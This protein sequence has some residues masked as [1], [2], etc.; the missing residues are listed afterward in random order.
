M[1]CGEIAAPAPARSRGASRMP[2]HVLLE[3]RRR[4][5]SFCARSASSS[6]SRPWRRWLEAGV[7][8]VERLERAAEALARSA[9]RPAAPAASSSDLLAAS[10]HALLGDLAAR[11][12]ND[13]GDVAS[14]RLGEYVIHRAA[15]GSSPAACVAGVGLARGARRRVGAHA[16]ARQPVRPAP[17]NASTALVTGSSPARGL[18]ITDGGNRLRDDA[19]HHTLDDPLARQARCAVGVV[20][21]DLV[22]QVPVR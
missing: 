3:R 18:S 10:P 19:L 7:P 15:R 4:R 12:S 14:A 8:D 22:A 20:R 17:A 13:A 21:L 6:A 16:A 5:D 2:R 1:C 11:R 9:P